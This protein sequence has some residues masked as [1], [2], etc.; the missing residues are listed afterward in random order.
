MIVSL[1]AGATIIDTNSI[2]TILVLLLSIGNRFVNGHGSFVLIRFDLSFDVPGGVS[3][4]SLILDRVPIRLQLINGA[5][6]LIHENWSFLLFP[7]VI[8]GNQ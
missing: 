3:S 7:T 6:S 4:S 8:P 2:Q 1:V 5:P